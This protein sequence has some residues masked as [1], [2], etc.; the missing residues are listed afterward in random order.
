MV[1][2]NPDQHLLVF[3]QMSVLE[4]TKDQQELAD[5]LLAWCIYNMQK[6]KTDKES[7]NSYW[8][9]PWGEKI[10][11]TTLWIYETSWGKTARTSLK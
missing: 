9:N 6:L 10:C 3:E 11:L 2:S 5:A 8:N 4:P 1:S 7:D